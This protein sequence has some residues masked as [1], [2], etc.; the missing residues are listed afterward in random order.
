MARE[1]LARETVGASPDR[2]LRE[3]GDAVEAIAAIR[4][5]ILVIEDLHWTDPSTLGLLMELA[6]RTEPARLL[7]IASYRP[8]DAP[9]HPLRAA[10]RG[11]RAKGSVAE[12]PVPLLTHDEAGAYVVARLGGGGL[13][14]DLAMRLGEQT[15]GNPLFLT[16]LVDELLEANAFARDG[17]RW[18]L[19]E[20]GGATATLPLRARD[21]M[22]N[23]VE[24]LT[25]EQ[26]R[27]LACGALVGSEFSAAAVAAGIDGVV[28]RVE[29]ECEALVRLDRFIRHE[30]FQSGPDGPVT[31]AYAFKHVVHRQVWLERVPPALR[32]SLHQRIG[33]GLEKSFGAR[34]GEIAANLARHFEGGAELE[35]ASRY[36]QVA[37]VQS[38]QRLAFREAVAYLDLALVQV[39]AAHPGVDSPPGEIPILILLGGAIA[40]AEGFTSPR[41]L[42]TLGRVVATQTGVTDVERFAALWGV[43]VYQHAHAAL[44]PSLA[45]A[46]GALAIADSTGAPWMIEAATYMVGM[47]QT[48]FRG[49]SLETLSLLARSIER[50]QRIAPD[51]RPPFLVPEPWPTATAFASLAS[52]L[53]GRLEEALA[54][55]AQGLDSPGA[56][57]FSM[58]I[59]YHHWVLH[60]WLRGE[61]ELAR[62]HLA[63]L[64]RVARQTA[65]VHW[66]ELARC[67]LGAITAAEGNAAEGASRIRRGVDRYRELGGA[68]GAPVL[69]AMLTGSPVCAGAH[70]AALAAADEGLAAAER[71]GEHWFTAELY[72]L[73]ALALTGLR[74]S[75]V[76]EALAN[77]NQVARDQTAVSLELRVA[78]AKAGIA[79]HAAE[80][81]AAADHLDSV[82]E[83][84]PADEASA[85]LVAAR[86]L[87][88]SIRR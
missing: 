60:H 7:V 81:S 22:S 37:A 23:Q 9:E 44:E 87:L 69:L 55:E 71:T 88:A 27:V 85:D 49:G 2:M 21:L 35:R 73:R 30:H 33:A 47:S 15:G 50:S 46:R 6:Q 67:D 82:L 28:D 10:L 24:K 84:L 56:H 19:R 65:S 45:A 75:G 51:T 40:G 61:T 83:R 29:A 42:A 3:F 41:V 52:W 8:E 39:R 43:W 20:P 86:S 70:E 58:A 36:L 78:I 57:P 17:S 72:R 38:M 16:S 76:E 4:P 62:L 77:A 34:A 31:R 32:E 13:E 80:R 48:H 25:P 54:F 14:G 68:I 79:T 26:Q 59:V 53:T 18:R 63:N 64:D 66:L 11:L 1:A 74:R 5:L 12:L